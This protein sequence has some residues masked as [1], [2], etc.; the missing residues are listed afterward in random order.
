MATCL[1][2][3][4]VDQVGGRARLCLQALF[5]RDPRAGDGIPCAARLPPGS[6]V[7]IPSIGLLVGIGDTNERALNQ[8]PVH[9]RNETRYKPNTAWRERWRKLRSLPDKRTKRAR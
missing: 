8:V 6:V 7:A 2:R 4:S 1:R 9:E 5:E 3:P